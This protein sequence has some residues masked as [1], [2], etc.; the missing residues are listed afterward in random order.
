V[1]L[2]HEGN[3][4][5]AV[6]IDATGKVTGADVAQTSGFNDLDDAAVQCVTESWHFTPA[7]MNGE[8]IAS[9][10]QY[11]IVW[12]FYDDTR[13]WLKMDSKGTCNSLFREEKQRLTSYRATTVAFRVSPEGNVEIPFVAISSGDRIYDAEAVACMNKL[14]Y[15][16]AFIG[17]APTEVSWVASILWSPQTGLAFADG[18]D[19][20]LYCS[21]ET[22]PANLWKGDPPNPTEISF[23]T[24]TDGSSDFAIEKKSGN[25]DLDQAALT[26]VKARKMTSATG[27]SGS[28]N[29]GYLFRFIWHDGHAFVLNI[30]GN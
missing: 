12:S 15:A 18:R 11:R 25:P 24:N 16:P 3:T 26:C 28:A 1:K 8:P 4:V 19:I 29:F 13:P 14:T 22:F 21:D 6:H 30:R 20:G 23:Q 2:N 27:P 17:G 9:T 5:V 7:T 10:K